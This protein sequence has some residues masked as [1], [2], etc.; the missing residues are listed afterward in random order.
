MWTPLSFVMHIILEVKF[1]IWKTTDLQSLKYNF[2]KQVYECSRTDM[3]R[4]DMSLQVPMASPF[5]NNMESR[6]ETLQMIS[7][8]PGCPSQQWSCPLPAKKYSTC[9]IDWLI[10]WL[11]DNFLLFY[12]VSTVFK[13]YNDGYMQERNIVIWFI[14][15]EMHLPYEIMNKTT[16]LNAHPKLAFFSVF[17]QAPCA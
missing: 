3:M 9:K 6:I 13:S 4:L 16:M 15:N 12:A 7:F 11:I 10:D 5:W 8:S 2:K 17:C 1:E 14:W